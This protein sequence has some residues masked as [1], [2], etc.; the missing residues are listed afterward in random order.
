MV[1][2]AGLRGPKN[3]TFGTLVF[4]R[5]NTL[6]LDN[7]NAYDPMG[8]SYAFSL[9]GFS[10]T[11][12]GAGNTEDARSNSAVKYTVAY[13]NFRAAGL[14]QV[15]D[16][17]QGNGAEALYQAD[18]GFDAYG[19]SFD[20][21]YSYAEDSVKLGTYNAPVGASGGIPSADPSDT[22]KATISNDTT[23]QLDGR[24]KWNALTLFGGFE[25]IQYADPTSAFATKQANGD[26]MTVLGGYPGVG[27]GNA[28][29]TPEHLQVY[30][31]GAKYAFTSVLTGTIAY[32]HYNQDF[33]QSSTTRIAT[34]STS[35]HSNCAG[36]EDVVSALLD[37]QFSAKFDTYAG[38]MFS[39]V[40]NGMA[41]G[42]QTGGRI[43]VDPT[44]GLR[45]RF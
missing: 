45:F 32:Y 33:Y 34:C 44:L 18:V 42:Y 16:Y 3:D 40:N 12:A 10:G 1:Q 27:Q 37:W 35:A 24:Y 7:V 19:F 25:W 36:S 39:E 14:A 8:G 15:G 29:I 38:V 22:L 28:F 43:N 5:V 17:E 30:W 9:I 23:F 2:L 26:Y 4:G 31:T 41:N 6:L 11:T 13:N 21:A 20:A